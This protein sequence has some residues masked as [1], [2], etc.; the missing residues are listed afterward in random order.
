MLSDY[1]AGQT[2]I[3]AHEYSLG[4][5]NKRFCDAKLQLTSGGPLEGQ[6]DNPRSDA[7]AGKPTSTLDVTAIKPTRLPSVFPV[8]QKLLSI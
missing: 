1:A 8:L 5:A 2:Q 4:V 6:E 3:S 7:N